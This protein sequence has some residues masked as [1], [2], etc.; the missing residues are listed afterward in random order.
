MRLDVQREQGQT[1]V[2]YSLGVA[3]W[4]ENTPSNLIRVMPA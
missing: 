3:A 2:V 4:P 1:V